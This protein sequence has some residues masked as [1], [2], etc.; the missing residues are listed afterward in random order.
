MRKRKSKKTKSIAR[1]CIIVVVR[2]FKIQS[3]YVQP[4]DDNGLWYKFRTS[5]LVKATAF[6]D[7]HFI[8]GYFTVYDNRIYKKTGISKKI[9]YFT[10][11]NK[12][13]T[14]RL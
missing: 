8:W 4:L 13:R 10:N 9:A 12:P 7:K 1:Y 5:N 3:K 11:S 2:G 14:A 6:L